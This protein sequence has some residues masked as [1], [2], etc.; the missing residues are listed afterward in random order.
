MHH[1]I[2]LDAL[3]A[4][5]YIDKKGS[6]TAAASALHRV[7]SALTYTVQKLESDLD[8]KLFDR[9][10]HRA[11]LTPAGRLLLAEGRH[12]LQAADRLEEAVK[13]VEAGWET[14]LRIA[15]DTI[16]PL[17]PLLQTIQDFNALNHQVDVHISEEVLGGTWE[18]L[19]ANRCDISLG[20]SGELPKGLFEFCKLGQVEFVFAVAPDHPLTQYT[21]PITAEAISAYPTVVVADSSLSA[22][23]RNSGLLERRQMLR[24][25]TMSA[26]LEAQMLGVGVG[27]LPRHLAHEAIAQGLLRAL[28]CNVPRPDIPIYMAWRKDNKGKAL[29]WFTHALAQQNLLAADAT[30]HLFA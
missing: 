9:S 29:A 16:L 22:P 18:A 3:R 4:I 7:P 27:F 5:D 28:P 26:K 30:S 10:G 21:D 11:I 2:T 6:F 12:L 24:V 1:A 14:R 13:Q 19:I 8:I 20:A 25:T 15:R 23:G 17:Q